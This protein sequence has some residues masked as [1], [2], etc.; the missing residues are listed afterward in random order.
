MKILII[1]EKWDLGFLSKFSWFL[2]HFCLF[3][4]CGSVVHLRTLQR[5]KEWHRNASSWIITC[6]VFKIMPLDLKR[7]QKQEMHI[8]LPKHPYYW[9]SCWN[10]L[11]L[12]EILYLL[13]TVNI[14]VSGYF[15]IRGDGIHEPEK[16]FSSFYI[17]KYC[18]SYSSKALFYRLKVEVS[19]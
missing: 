11:C 10:Q 15:N 19:F 8:L 13:L 1:Y 3:H 2:Y 5:S 12:Y 18:W 9:E 7:K 14:R 6:H 16:W 17:K 4:C